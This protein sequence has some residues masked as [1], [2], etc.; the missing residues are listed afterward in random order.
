MAWPWQKE[1]WAK[2]SNTS[3][4]TWILNLISFVQIIFF[5]QKIDAG[6]QKN[7]FLM[8]DFSKSEEFLPQNLRNS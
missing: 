7:E 8:G 4:T 6:S 2:S 1:A 5:D 3:D